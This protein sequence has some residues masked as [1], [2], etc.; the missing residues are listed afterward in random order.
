MKVQQ[1]SYQNNSILNRKQQGQ[2]VQFGRQWAEHIS[3][4]ANYIKNTGKTNFKLFSFPDAKAVLLELTKNAKIKAT[5][6]WEHFINIKNPETLATASSAAAI[7]AISTIDDKSRLIPMEHKGDGIYEL[8]NVDAKPGDGYRYVVIQKDGSVNTVKDPYSKQQDNIHGWSGVYDSTAYKWENTNWLEGK[9]PRRIIRKPEEPLRGLEKLI[10]EEV[11]I[12]TMSKEGTIEK[13]K[14]RIAEIAKKNVAT[15]IE[16]MPI[17]NTYS[18][19]WGYDGVDKFAINDKIG[20]PDK[21]KELVDFAHGLGLNVIIDMVPNHIGPD[22]NYLSQT[23][24]YKKCA[25]KY[26]DMLNY[27]GEN[28]KYVR[29]W[30]VNA[31]LSWAN[32]FK[33]DGI[34]FDL[35]SDAGSDWLLRQT[36][37]ELNEHNPQVFTIAEDHMKK[38]HKLTNYYSNPNISHTDT[39]N[40]LDSQVDMIRNGFPTEPWSIGF[41]SEW[42]SQYKDAVVD[43]LITPDANSLDQID[44][45][46]PYSHYRIHYAYS[47]DEIGN[48][49]GTKFIP[50]FLV[51]ALGLYDKVSCP[52]GENRGQEAAKASQKIAELAVSKEFPNMDNGQL[53]EAE[54]AMGLNSF[55]DKHTIEDSFNTA[56]AKQKLFL[57]TIFTTPGPKMYFQGDDEADLSLFKFF[58]ELHGDKRKGT[59]GVKTIEEAIKEKGYDPLEEF[60]R[61][62]SIV[63]RIKPNG[64]FKD[65]KKQ[66]VDFSSDLKS[67]IDKYPVLT[68]GKVER[69]YKDN[70]HNVHVHELTLDGEDMLIIKNYGNGFHWDSYEYYDFPQN[71]TWKEIFSSDDKKYGGMNYCNKER[72]DITN[73]NQHLSLAPNSFIILKKIG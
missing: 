70:H 59:R 6:W 53:Y 38:R 15:A 54:K 62:D 52:N 69:T 71:S 37:I 9:D 47:H 3:W 30:M 2:N 73:L 61:P 40:L 60:A 48:F 45:F 32:E 7:A 27:E 10:I 26:G 29:D 67:L 41:D 5:N 57:G 8:N 31:A 17:E 21:F 34:R 1:I 24:P 46:L 55:I 36:I 43:M 58:R 51:G 68:K 72:N 12:P 13:A 16:I 20:G 50:K 11:N 66:M 64:I 44:K 22:G 39:L 63:G 42:D 33:V 23:G 25:S 19:Q 4:G 35:T 28:N 56:V 49:D 14:T 18:M 65:L